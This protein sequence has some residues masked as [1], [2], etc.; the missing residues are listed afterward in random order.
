MTNETVESLHDAAMKDADEAHELARK[1]RAKFAEAAELEWRSA[2]LWRSEENAAEPTWSILRRSAI[3][4]WRSA[5]MYARADRCEAEYPQP[6]PYK[7]AVVE[8]ETEDGDP[9]FVG[10]AVRFYCGSRRGALTDARAI[11]AAFE[12]ALAAERERCARIV[13]SYA[14]TD[15]ER[16]TTAAAAEIRW[17]K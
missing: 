1:A 13:E 8:P 5:G 9:V 12:R 2:L 6:K 14:N 10:G 7:F 15:P 11:N 4:L 16:A 3:C 17:S